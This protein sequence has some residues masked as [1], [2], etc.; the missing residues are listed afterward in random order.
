VSAVR[1]PWTN[2]PPA[3]I[4]QDLGFCLDGAMAAA[5]FDSVTFMKR[6]VLSFSA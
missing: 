4:A 5:A 1:C 6:S 3:P 2:P